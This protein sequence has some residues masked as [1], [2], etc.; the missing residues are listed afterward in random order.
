M[1]GEFV[2][3]MVGNYAEPHINSEDPIENQEGPV[4]KITGL[5][6]VKMLDNPKTTLNLMVYDSEDI[7][8][9]QQIEMFKQLSEKYTNAQ[10]KFI[11][12]DH[13]KNDI[14]G[15]V[16][17]RYPAYF[18]IKDFGQYKAYH[19]DHPDDN[20]NEEEMDSSDEFSK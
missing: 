4:Q 16:A 1:L 18:I 15:V 3:A 7:D 14:T 5:E 20:V 12:L 13:A 17:H 9:E 2:D 19:L 10:Y 8:Y 6:F 11:M